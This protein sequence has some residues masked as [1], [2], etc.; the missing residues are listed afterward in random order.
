M[1]QWM[2]DELFYCRW[3][4]SVNFTW[5]LIKAF[6]LYRNHTDC[7]RRKDKKC[8]EKSDGE[9]ESNKP[10]RPYPEQ[11]SWQATVST[12][13]GVRGCVRHCRGG[14]R[15]RPVRLCQRNQSAPKQT[16]R[17]KGRLQII[18][19]NRA[20]SGEKINI[21]MIILHVYFVSVFLSM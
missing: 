14:G 7:Y 13:R 3:L 8:A 12:K 10:V 5:W 20:F 21:F 11:L 4:I 2:I 18:E 16:Q 9:Q 19:L 17:I 6:W 1:K 15:G